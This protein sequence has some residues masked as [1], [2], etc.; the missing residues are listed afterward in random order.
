MTASPSPS[1]GRVK[2]APWGRHCPRGER[3]L[4]S[5]MT[6]R[7]TSVSWLNAHDIVSE[8]MMGRVGLSARVSV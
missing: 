7:I 5:N 2:E 3:G 8:G 1:P 4:S 6:A